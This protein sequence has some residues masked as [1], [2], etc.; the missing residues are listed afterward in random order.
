MR[1]AEDPSVSRTEKK[2]HKHSIILQILSTFS[3]SRFRTCVHMSVL[4]QNRS[5]TEP[6]RT[7]AREGMLPPV[8][9]GLP[10]TPNGGPAG[11][12]TGR[13]NCLQ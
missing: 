3:S 8:L 10:V 6:R 11:H 5:V 13:L 4:Q 9:G 2:E 12:V 1:G 7:R